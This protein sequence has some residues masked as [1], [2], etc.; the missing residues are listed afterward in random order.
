MI[1]ISG[2]IKTFEELVDGQRI[3]FPIHHIVIH[4]D[5]AH[6]ASLLLLIRRTRHQLQLP[7][8]TPLIAIS[9]E[10]HS[11]YRMMASPK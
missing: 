3:Q 6:K 7:E 4:S 5:Y 9:P 11:M 2:F 8:V 10:N 1:S